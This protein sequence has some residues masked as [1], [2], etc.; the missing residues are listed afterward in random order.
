MERLGVLSRSHAKSAT[1]F[2]DDSAVPASF[3]PATAL[4]SSGCA[5]IV[6]EVSAR[7]LPVTGRESWVTL[8]G[9]LTAHFHHVLLP[10]KFWANPGQAS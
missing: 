2:D 10:P 4:T 8:R 3:R 1:S 7:L 9:Q 6:V 5:S